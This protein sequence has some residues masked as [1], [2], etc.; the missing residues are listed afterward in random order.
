MIDTFD[1]LFWIKSFEH[2][3]DKFSVPMSWVAALRLYAHADAIWVTSGESNPLPSFVDEEATAM[4]QYG[5][6]TLMDSR[7]AL[8]PPKTFLSCET[9]RLLSSAKRH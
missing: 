8:S 7:L 4:N 1:A 9:R 6:L 3:A 5:R 2:L